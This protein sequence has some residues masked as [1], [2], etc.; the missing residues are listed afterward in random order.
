[1]WKSLSPVKAENGLDVIILTILT[2]VNGF[3]TLHSIT[4]NFLNGR[5]R[6]N[7]ADH[8]T[9]G[10][11]SNHRHSNTVSV[12]NLHAHRNHHTTNSHAATDCDAFYTSIK[13]SDCGIP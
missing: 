3:E 2:G 10:S 13:H 12:S 5:V 11:D 6:T 9:G 1:M 4:G 7:L 8:P